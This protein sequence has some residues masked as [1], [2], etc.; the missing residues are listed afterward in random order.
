MSDR[1]LTPWFMRAPEKG[2][3]RVCRECGAELVEESFELYGDYHCRSCAKAIVEANLIPDLI[4][5]Y[6]SERRSTD[7]WITE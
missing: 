2:R 5:E 3:Y 7:T 6:L 4:D 1:P